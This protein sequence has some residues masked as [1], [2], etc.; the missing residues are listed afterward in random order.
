MPP[1]TRV[2]SDIRAVAKRAGVSISTISRFLN[3]KKRVSS[4]TEQRILS[5]VTT[6][7]YAPNRVARSLRQ[8]RTMTL[9]ILVPDNSNPFFAGLVKGA[10]DAARA[11]GF[12]LV[13]FD[14][15]EDRAQERAHLEALQALR[16]DGALLIAAPAGD[17][18][19]ERWRGLDR[20]PLPLVAVDR[21]VPFAVDTVVIDNANG[22]YEA[23]R[24]LVKLG[25]QRI[26]L[27]TVEYDV[28]THR[29]RRSGYVRALAE[30]GIERRRDHE[31]RVPL[32]VNDGFAGASRLLELA[33][34]PTAIFVT[35]N[36]LT[37]GAVAAI[38]ARGLRCPQD[39]SVIG[40]DSYDWQEV[41]QPR[42][43]TVKQPSYLM[44]QRAAELLLERI[45]GRKK[46]PPEKVVLRS[47]LILR[48]SCDVVRGSRG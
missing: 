27:L 37:I 20:F 31:V 17:D 3:G 29:D 16:C 4:D 21:Q 47:S 10:Q 24:Q 33:D 32:T 23:V 13:L 39:V 40:Y 41:F 18:E 9:G 42:L 36:A 45:A 14:T 12:A 28:S 8:G 22:G 35:S 48:E 7:G 1:A 19:G 5:A 26:G 34:A 43:S 11:A 30:A 15:N 44:G 46:G 6:L 25:H 38:H 2:R